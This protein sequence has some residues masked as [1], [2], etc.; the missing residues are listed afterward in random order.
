ML[1]LLNKDATRQAIEDA[2]T[3]HLAR[4][5]KDD[6]VIFYYSGHGGSDVCNDPD[7]YYLLPH[8]LDIQNMAATAVSMNRIARFFSQEVPAERVVVITDACHSGVVSE[9]FGTTRGFTIVHGKGEETPVNNL[10]NNYLLALSQSAGKVVLTA[11]RVKELSWESPVW[12]GG[13]GVFT[14]FLLKGLYGEA[15]HPDH[16]GDDDGVV[17]IRELVYYL[18]LKVSPGVQRVF[19]KVQS[20]DH[21]G[22]FT[23]NFPLAVLR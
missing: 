3:H 2:L 16:G 21:E 22:S 20:P 13:H 1:L 6:I 11:S 12:G 8:D 17:N 18:S 5:R 15:D 7:T 10:L 4:A 9:G 23:Q 14:Y 19:Q